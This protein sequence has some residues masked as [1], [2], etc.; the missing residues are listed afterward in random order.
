VGGHGLDR[1]EVPWTVGCMPGPSVTVPL[2]LD[3]LVS[4]GA[5]TEAQL[6]A[7]LG[8]TR[9]SIGLNQLEVALVGA[10]V[11]SASR[12]LTLKGVV[13]GL[14]VYDDPT[15]P[16]DPVLEPAVVRRLGAM[17]LH[18]QPATVAMVE[19]LPE[20]IEVLEG[21]LG[22]SFDVWLMT[23]PQFDEVFRAV[24]HGD[25][26]VA[27]DAVRD[28]FE[29]LDEAVRRR[30]SDIHLT[31]GEP[32]AVRVDGNLIRLNRKPLA[33]D[34]LRAEMVKL[35]GEER[36]QVW[37]TT[38]DVDFAVA[39]GPTR[40]RVNLGRDRIGM[41]VAAR[42]IPTD[43]PSMQ[44]LQLPEAVRKLCS[45][46]RGLVLVVGPTGSGKSTTLAAM[47]A[48]IAR[49]QSRHIITLEDPVEFMIPSSRS[50]V[51]QRELHQS[52]DSFSAGLRQALRQDP[53]IVFVGEMRDIETIRTALVAAET[54]HLV[55]GTLHTFDAA[56]T[57]AR[58]VSSF[59]ADEQDQVR[60][61]LSYILKGV[62]AQSLLPL[63]SGK[64]RVAAFEVMVT[65]AAISNNLRKV[66]GHS[67]IRQTIE[68]SAKEGM[69]TMEMALVDLVRRGVV[70]I[71]E[72]EMRAPDRE[73]FHRRL[74]RGEF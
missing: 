55:L 46:E 50:V 20:T 14:E 22:T 3:A 25:Q 43:I 39:Y 52:F 65:N 35:A 24:Y 66:D 72:A 40:F 42:K 32:P 67:Q 70:R 13:S 5:A 62:V 54:G 58:V 71:E 7:V 19:D 27:V 31:V 47:L 23:A 59:P 21:M 1:G 68:T 51:H 60:A 38:H 6:V 61:Q 44:E 26:G 57:V 17:V 36:L 12:L 34:F 29:I 28:I 53:D 56:S 4:S 37:D 49:S 63:G 10:G 15:V 41:T 11:I 33:Q 64:G 45:L 74:E 30:A 73:A 69:Q 16:V 48:D 2:L 18:R 9:H 8:E